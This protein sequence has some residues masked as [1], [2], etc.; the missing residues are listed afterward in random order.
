ME[1]LS[2]TVLMM[3][4]RILKPPELR[5][6]RTRGRKKGSLNCLGELLVLREIS[7][8]STTDKIERQDPREMRIW[9]EGMLLHLSFTLNK[10]KPLSQDKLHL[11][12]LGNVH[13]RSHLGNLEELRP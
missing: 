2:A 10:F 3:P 13:H 11:H 4:C 6:F 1:N 5:F 8:K 7:G 9:L 12:V